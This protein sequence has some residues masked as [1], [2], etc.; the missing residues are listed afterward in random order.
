MPTFTLNQTVRLG[1]LEQL[2]LVSVDDIGGVELDEMIVLPAQHGTLTVRT[3]DTDGSL[4]MSDPNHGIVAGQVIDLYWDSGSRYQALAGAVA[5]DVV[6][7]HSVGGGGDSLPAA[8]TEMSVG[9]PS[10]GPFKVTGSNIKGL[11]LALDQG[12]D[13]WFVFDVAGTGTVTPGQAV[14]ITGGTPYL[15]Y[16]GQPNVSNPIAGLE[17]LRLYVSTRNENQ[18]TTPQAG[19]INH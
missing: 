9:I 16:S 10:D 7:F 18:A 3:D 13:G 5:G 4:T 1:N 17:L 6:P 12:W 2:Q 14:Y 19:V 15:W 11:L 8:A